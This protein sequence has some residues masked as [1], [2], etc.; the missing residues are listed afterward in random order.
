MKFS[1]SGRE[2]HIHFLNEKTGEKFVLEYQ[3]YNHP[4]NERWWGM[5]T[6]SGFDQGVFGSFNFAG[7]PFDDE[8]LIVTM[9]NAVIM[10][11]NLFSEMNGR[12]DLIT[13]HSVEKGVSQK[14]L[15]E[16]H[17]HYE[18]CMKLED[19]FR[20]VLN[21]VKMLNLFIHRMES[22]SD[23][24]KN[25]CGIIDITAVAYGK[26]ALL[27][28][29]YRLFSADWIWGQLTL[30]YCLLG[31]PTLQAFLN[32][33]TPVPQDKYSA[34]MIMTFV[35]DSPFTRL[36]EFRSWAVSVGL[37][38]DDPRIALGYLP[39]GMMKNIPTTTEDKERFLSRLGQHKKIEKVI[40]VERP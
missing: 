4:F 21:S 5:L 2:V 26:K 11:M 16:L 28:E 31:V 13:P 1:F 33:S 19:F 39:L 3:L 38:P 24:K 32:Q 15:N 23:G 10:K 40:Q 25:N 37:N 12:A 8:D 7:Q 35:D 22:F 9:L 17:D 14:V 27:D 6:E 36:D 29:D 20:P 30:S 34:G 18:K